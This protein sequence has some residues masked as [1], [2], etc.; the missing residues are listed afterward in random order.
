[1]EYSTSHDLIVCIDEYFN[2]L[3]ISKGTRMIYDSLFPDNKLIN[4]CFDENN[5]YNIMKTFKKNG[6]R[7]SSK[8]GLDKDNKETIKITYWKISN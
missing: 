7:F 5:I 8:S 3:Y 4:R 1:M 2:T 6:Y